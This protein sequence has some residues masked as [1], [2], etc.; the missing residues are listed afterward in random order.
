MLDDPVHPSTSNATRY[1]PPSNNEAPDAFSKFEITVNL[2]KPKKDGA[3]DVRLARQALEASRLKN[4]S[5]QW[6]YSSGS[7]SF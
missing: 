7:K 5:S 3:S 1:N 6:L 4:S 2:P